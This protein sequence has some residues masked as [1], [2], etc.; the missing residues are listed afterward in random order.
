MSCT[1]KTSRKEEEREDGW[2]GKERREGFSRVA[3]LYTVRR[4]IRGV[5]RLGKR[6]PLGLLMLC[7]ALSRTRRSY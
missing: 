3:L 6:R 5:F 2:A 7:R 4:E 1:G